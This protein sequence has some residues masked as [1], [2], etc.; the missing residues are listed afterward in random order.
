MP[1]SV[2]IGIESF[3]PSHDGQVGIT[4]LSG[5][6]LLCSLW[7]MASCPG[8]EAAPA[9]GVRPDPSP[10]GFTLVATREGETIGHLTI[11]VSYETGTVSFVI[12]AVFVDAGFRRRGVAR[13][14]A[15]V[16]SRVMRPAIDAYGGSVRGDAGHGPGK[17]A[18]LRRI[19][20]H[21]STH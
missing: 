17:E 12:E 20:D 16:A 15:R 14:L 6:D 5:N 19:A 8:D 2:D 11:S 18:I 4:I 21:I 1:G 10:D 9:W 3:A 7:D 13:S